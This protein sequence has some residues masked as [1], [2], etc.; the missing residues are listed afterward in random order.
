MPTQA[1]RAAAHQR[2]TLVKRG[3]RRAGGDPPRRAAPEQLSAERD[4]E[5][6]NAEIGDQRSVQRAN[7]RADGET[8]D[9]RDDPDRGI[10]ETE[11]VRQQ[12]DLRDADDGRSEAEDRADRKVD[13]AHHDDQHHAGRHHRDRGGLDQQI[14]QI[15]R[16]QEQ[17][18]PVD[19]HRVDVKADPDQRQRADHPEH[20][21]V[22]FGGAQQPAKQ[23]FFR[24]SAQRA[25]RC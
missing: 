15:A 18:L 1:K 11:I 12:I 10:V 2:E 6:G 25:R 21:G 17:A 5:S 7:R 3:D 13:V 20:A 24:R 23:R 14:P 8:E 9:Q 4:D 22:D 16:R 19:D